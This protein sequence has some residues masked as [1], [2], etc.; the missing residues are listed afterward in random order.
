MATNPRSTISERTDLSLLN[1]NRKK[2]AQPQRSLV[3]RLVSTAIALVVLAGVLRYLP[4]GSRNAQAHAGS[5]PITALP[6]DLQL[7]SLQMSQAPD[8]EALYLYLDGVVRNT[9]AANVTGAT[10][11][12]DFHDVQGKAISSI[13]KPIVSMAHGGTDMIRNEFARNPIQP[14]E[15]RFFRVAIDQ[16]P[17]AWNHELPELKVVEVKAR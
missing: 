7:G 9:G 13:Q 12:V 4:P 6:D 2:T 1:D 15:M 5:V 11:E 10:V 14:N 16:V 3:G 17:P 8:G